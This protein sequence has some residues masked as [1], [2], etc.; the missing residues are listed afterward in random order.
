MAAVREMVATGVERTVVTYNCLI[1]ACAK[2]AQAGPGPSES[3][4]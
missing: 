4:H 1:N 2:G 3:F